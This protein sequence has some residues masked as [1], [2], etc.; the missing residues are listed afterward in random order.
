MD[1]ATL[2]TD[3]QGL[4]SDEVAQRRAR[5]EV[6]T[7]S[8]VSSRTRLDIVKANLFTRFNALIVVLAA[9]VIAV[10]ELIDL[11]FALV[12]VANAAIG[13]FQ[14]LRAKRTLDHLIV[15]VASTVE[16]VRDGVK[17]AVA[18]GD[19]VTGDRILLK[20]GDQV[21]V[22]AK[23]TDVDGCEVDE[24]ALT[25]EADPVVKQV[26]DEVRSGS[27]VV[28]GSAGVV[29]TRVG[30]DVWIHQL[31]QQAKTFDPVVSELRGAIDQILRYISWMVGPLAALL[32][33]SQ[34]RSGSSAA[35]GLVSAVAGIVAL[36]PQGLV[37]LVS[38]TMAT[39][40]VRLARQQ[41]VVK[42]LGAVEGL[43][44]VDVICV[45]KTG[46]LTTGRLA[47][48]AIEPIG[49]AGVDLHE[50]LAALAKLAA[51]ETS[52]TAMFTLIAAEVG[53]P[54]DWHVIRSVAFSSARKWSGTTFTGHGTW[55]I[56]A[57]EI[58]LDAVGPE[59]TSAAASRLS[60]LASSARRVLLV[61]W[62][63]T[64]FGAEPQLPT[65]LEP[66]GVV[67]MNEEL[68]PDAAQTMRYFLD[69]GVVVKVISG[70]N[71]QTVAA[72]AQQLGLP[73][74]DKFIDLRDV[75]QPLA[76]IVEAY[77]VF[78]RVL[79][80]QK[81]ELVMALQQAGHTVAMTGDGVNDIP[82][83]KA[84][85]IGIAMDTATPAT[86][87]VADVVLLNGRFD[88]LP[89]VVAEGRRVIANM[90]RVSSLFVTKTVY[91]T[92]F[93]LVAGLSQQA[94]PFLPRHLSLIADLTVGVPAFVL[95]FRPT[96][97]RLRLGYLRRV[98]QFSLPTGCGA[99][100][101][102]MGVYWLLRS[103]LV[104]ASLREARTGATIA[105]A[106]CGFWVLYRLIRPLDGGEVVLLVILTLSFVAVFAI[107]PI[108]RLYA[109]HLPASNG[110][111]LMAAAVAGGLSVLQL[112]LNRV[113]REEQ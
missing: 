46:T 54:P 78:G 36:V 40:V 113:I 51:D 14:E 56:G 10:G 79:P 104:G 81:R 41:V 69:E 99:A 106:V 28:A 70:D 21:P 109:L 98:I 37:L 3:R 77:T 1:Q 19:L 52:P 59:R 84:A 110:L 2:A 95:G 74:A 34:L 11:T 8:Q 55:I 16:V 111:L 47:L 112:V 87:A 32:V 20:V 85:D 102:T 90:E 63:S 39:A 103:G 45:D 7:V 73:G 75:D 24:S 49:N 107:V 72:V 38:V 33:W 89:G 48:E 66:V 67:I 83:V 26:G 57:P 53:M 92:V 4:S 108:A 44:R 101:V 31:E 5:G 68:R 23:V 9:V 12:M 96:S 58:I 27:A 42:E 35:H 22:D 17:Q 86:K 65:G 13:I 18:V 91:A 105:L 100:A 29:A 61:A 43:A 93:A 62:T 82:A 15:L 88:L 30:D 60:Q 80:E 76:T 71:A 6:N 94:Y 97:Q 64:E 25:G 50:G